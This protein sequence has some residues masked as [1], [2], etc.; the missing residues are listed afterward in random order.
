VNNRLATA[1]FRRLEQSRRDS[2]TLRRPYGEESRFAGALN[3]DGAIF[4]VTGDRTH[5]LLYGY[6]GE[7]LS[8]FRGNTIFMEPSRNP[9]ATPL[10]YTRA[11]LLSGYIHRDFEPLIRNS[12][13]IVVSYL[14]SGRVILMTDNPNFRAVWYGT[15]RLFLNSVFFG[16]ILRQNP[17]RGSDVE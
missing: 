16:P 14:R 15:N 12:A 7:R 11:P 1:R 13:S 2:L 8:I 6:D 17:P 9:Y 3:I 5:P 4:E 10:V